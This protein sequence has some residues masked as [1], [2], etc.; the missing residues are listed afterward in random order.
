LIKVQTLHIE[1]FRGIRNLRL[2]VDGENLA[3]RGPNGSG[4]SGIVDAIE[5]AL[6]GNITR[7]TGTG[8]GAVSIRTHAPHVDCKDNPEKAKVTL[9]LT[10]PSGTKF[11]LERNVASPSRPTV[12]PDSD[13][14]RAALKYILTHPEFSLS[15]REILKFVLTEA[16]KRAK[17]IQALLKLEAIDKNRAAFQT[18][19]N[20]A[21]RDASSAENVLT[22]ARTNLI[23]HLKISEL[24]QETVLSAVNDRRTVLGLKTYGE[25]TADI[26]V[27][28]GI[29]SESSDPKKKIPRTDAIAKADRILAFVEGTLTKETPQTKSALDAVSRLESQPDLLSSLS[30]QTL[31]ET[32]VE[33]VIDS[34]CPLCDDE[35]DQNKLLAHLRA[36][37]EKNKSAVSVKT[38]INTGLETRMT[39]IR[40]I[41]HELEQLSKYATTLGLDSDAKTILEG[42]STLQEIEKNLNQS[43]DYLEKTKTALRNPGTL[44]PDVLAVAIQNLKTELSTLPD[45]S[46]AEA[47]KQFLTIADERL[48]S[49]R[50]A[51]SDY[52]MHKKRAAA[53]AALLK[54][55]TESSEQKLSTLYDDVESDF[56]K[57]YRDLNNDD[58]GGF[59][60]RLEPQEGALNFEVDFHGR[61]K[62]PPNAYHS[63]GHQDGMGLCLYFALSKKL[64]GAS[65]SL[66]LLDDVLMSVDAGHRR[67]VCKLLRAEFPKTQF[68]LTTHDEVW[69]KQLTLEGIVKGKNLLQFRK[70]TVDDGPAAWDFGEVW[71]EI[72]TDL[73]GNDVSAAS[74]GLRRYMEFLMSELAFK[75]RAVIEARPGATYDLGELMP[76]VAA[77]YKD[78]L[79]RAKAAANSWNQQDVVTSVAA[80][81]DRFGRK[82]SATNAEQWAVNAAVHY[83]EWANLSPTDFRDVLKCFRELIDELK[84][85]ACE[86][87]FYAS[88]LKGALDTV[89]CDCG[90]TSLNLK[91]R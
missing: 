57:F 80:L 36:K 35:W 34:A 86:G 49:Y 56:A 63:E 11:T 66:C 15:R 30:R 84:C 17:E 42:Q 74:Q 33:L 21:T 69:S 7:L 50:K 67:E 46:S 70:W 37:I 85:T 54:H 8:S 4:K 3:V 39:L 1:H 28:D 43:I 25:L 87:W 12:D 90:Q 16:G 78:L 22:T 20:A 2:S 88:P 51:K 60:A 32:G 9:G 38:A 14:T 82:Y 81:D 10:L 72:E 24:T 53:A 5:F 47:A 73:S 13:E 91:T 75:L 23:S 31:F 77:R 45:L 59:S 64:L 58:E 41:G 27:S 6:T 62:F 83:N 61:G 68:I 52:E 89:K 48:E 71:N 26:K 18:A 55:F 76:A 29:T 79:R 44:L 19:S 65:F 40:T